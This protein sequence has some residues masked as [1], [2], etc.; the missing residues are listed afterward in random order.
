ALRAGRPP[1]GGGRRDRAAAAAGRVAARVLRRRGAG[2]DA[3]LLAVVLRADVEARAL[4]AADIQHPVGPEGDGARRVAPE[5]LPPTGKQRGPGGHHAGRGVDRDPLQAVRHDAA[6][7]RRTGRRGT[8]VA[9]P[10][11]RWHTWA[12]AT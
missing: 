8:G 9:H 2:K 1:W 12:V 3:A 10:V 5:L 6:I 11:G 7:A 4:A